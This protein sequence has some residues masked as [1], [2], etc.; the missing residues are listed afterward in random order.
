MTRSSH[1]IKKQIDGFGKS[2]KWY[3]IFGCVPEIFTLMPT[4][5]LHVEHYC[6][7]TLRQFRLQN[8]K[9]FLF[10]HPEAFVDLCLHH[11][12]KPITG[13]PFFVPRDYEN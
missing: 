8:T 3:V 11:P 10:V 5:W 9:L 12:T 4:L 6:G 1:L 7:E 2:V 13:S